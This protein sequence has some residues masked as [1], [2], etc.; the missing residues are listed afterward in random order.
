VASLIIITVAIITFLFIKDFILII[1]FFL[2]INSTSAVIIAVTVFSFVVDSTSILIIIIIT[3]VFFVIVIIV[4]LIFLF[5]FFLPIKPRIGEVNKIY[6][7]FFV[8]LNIN[9][10]ILS[11]LLSLLL[12]RSLSARK[13]SIFRFLSLRILLRK[14]IIFPVK[15]L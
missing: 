11:S 10:L 13:S 6:F 15:T 1:I 7:F 5:A 3:A 9:S 12:E 2:V 8:I 4:F 14:I